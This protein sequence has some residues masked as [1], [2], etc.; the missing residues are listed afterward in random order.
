MDP[1]QHRSVA[2][3]VAIA[4]A[5]A[6]CGGLVQSSSD[7]PI[8]D[9]PPGVDGEP[10]N[11]EPGHPGPGQPSVPVPKPPN[12]VQRCS[13][14]EGPWLIDANGGPTELA[15]RVQNAQMFVYVGV[16]RRLD[17]YTLAGTSP[18]VLERDP[19]FVPS[20]ARGDLYDVAIDDVGNVWASSTDQLQRAFPLPVLKCTLGPGYADDYVGDILLDADGNGGWGLEGPDGKL[21]RLTLGASSC[22]VEL[23]DS[24]WGAL[25]VRPD[26]PR[27]SGGRLHVVDAPAPG[28]IGIFTATGTLVKTY[29][30]KSAP[31]DPAPGGAA[32]CTGGVCVFTVP[33][34]SGTQSIVYLDEDG[35]PR[36]P[37]VPLFNGLRANLIASAGSGAVFVAGDSDPAREAF[38]QVVIQM[39]PAPP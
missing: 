30:G 38:H 19:S 27:D 11:A 1:S 37:A 13:F 17:R 14:K 32:L 23:A 31:T 9:A 5:V 15:V 22:S 18:C 7:A 12:P 10:P 6:G 21:S 36:A 35:N 20:F 34:A 8:D 39:A 25:Q 3:V 33:D 4:A 29:T 26:T 16:R 2:R 28:A 24:P